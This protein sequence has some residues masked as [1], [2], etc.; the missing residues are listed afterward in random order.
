MRNI[1]NRKWTALSGGLARVLV[2][3]VLTTL[4]LPAAGS[5]VLQPPAA[6]PAWLRA[7]ST[8]K[9]PDDYRSPGDLHKVIVESGDTVQERILRRASF[10]NVYQYHRRSLYLMSSEHLLK[11]PQGE[12]ARLNVRDD[13]NLIR[14]RD[15]YFDTTGPVPEVSAD[16]SLTAKP[17]GQLH[18][19]QFVG[20]V[21]RDWIDHLRL[22]EGLTI[23]TYVPE[24]AY[25]VW[26]GQSAR[27]EL[28]AWAG[29]QYYVQWHGPFHPA[30]KLH[31][32]FDLGYS[33]DVNATIQLVTH[34]GVE[35]SIAAIRAKASRVLRDAYTVGPYTS[36]R[37]NHFMKRLKVLSKDV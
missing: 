4:T 6:R 24:N 21:Q 18:L 20:P 9:V 27:E 16:L 13:L 36:I 5:A 28:A 14:L 10:L 25:L 35:A 31:P 8:P 3:M 19:V 32:G 29:F 22:I 15:R 33:G 23:V 7:W 11:L 26:A 37:V 1:H 12:R 2:V 17:G 34:D 30:Y